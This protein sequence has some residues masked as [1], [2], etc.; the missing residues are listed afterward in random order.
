MKTQ[1]SNN[2]ISAIFGSRKISRVVLMA[3]I[4]VPIFLFAVGFASWTIVTPEFGFFANG[5]FVG[6]KLLDSTRYIKLKD[7]YAPFTNTYMVG[8]FTN[9]QGEVLDT[10][11]FTID[12]TIKLGQC[13]SLFT[14]AGEKLYFTFSLCFADRTESTTLFNVDNFTYSAKLSTSEGY[15]TLGYNNIGGWTTSEQDIAQTGVSV[16]NYVMKSST[17]T[18]ETSTSGSYVFVIVFDFS[19]ADSSFGPTSADSTVTLSIDY[20]LT[21]KS[22]TIY[23]ELMDIILGVEDN[24]QTGE[25]DNQKSLMI[26]VR[27]TDY[28]PY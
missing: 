7:E 20:M 4:L 26:D 9:D 13:Q 6:N 1:K 24:L 21:P 2:F 14:E 15:I 5:G 19:E 12:F 25:T 18:I 3:Y 22:A 16:S 8:G 27:I 23:R 11:K 17:N 10:S 28:N